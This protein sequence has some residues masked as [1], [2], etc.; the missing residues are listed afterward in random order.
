MGLFD[1][2]L[3]PLKLRK[4]I[5]S[6]DLVRGYTPAAMLGALPHSPTLAYK[7]SKKRKKRKRRLQAKGM[8]VKYPHRTKEMRIL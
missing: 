2:L 7:E 3:D 5:S 8:G 6:S 4:K 1:S